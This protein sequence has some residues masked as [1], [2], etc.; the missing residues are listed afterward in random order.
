MDASF[1]FCFEVK[2]NST[3]L[4]A[5][6]SLSHM[7]T[8]HIFPK[9]IIWSFFFLT[10]I[11]ILISERL[12]LLKKVTRKTIWDLKRI[13]KWIWLTCKQ[14]KLYRVYHTKNIKAFLNIQYGTFV[15]T[16][17][18]TLLQGWFEILV[19]LVM[20][21]VTCRSATQRYSN[22]LR[23]SIRPSVKPN[24]VSYLSLH[25]SGTKKLLGPWLNKTEFYLTPLLVHK[26]TW[27]Q[28]NSFWTAYF[29]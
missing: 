4:L 7:C 9:T 21:I 13:L 23:P 20:F 14:G 19:A 8:T 22:R 10:D 18:M 3:Q 25:E 28:D 6:S 29:R 27:L 12:N 24:T 1:S 16:H 5:F 15:W 17:Q 11:Y 26:I 2:K